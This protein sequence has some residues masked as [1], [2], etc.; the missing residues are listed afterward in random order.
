M[1]VAGLAVAT[2]FV[3]PIVLPNVVPNVADDA[4]LPHDYSAATDAIEINAT[5]NLVDSDIDVN[6]DAE[7]G[8]G[9]GTGESGIPTK[10]RKK[11]HKAKYF[12]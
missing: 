3:A 10:K 9:D 8:V 2:G 6:H 12:E 4:M 7:D 1:N 11:S 5:Q